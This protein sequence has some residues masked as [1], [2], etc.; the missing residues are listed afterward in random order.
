M[1]EYNI[2]G[3]YMKLLIF[4]LNKAEKFDLLLKEFAANDITGATIIS[5][6]GMA[7]ELMKK[8]DLGIIGSFR[9]L[10]DNNRRENKT[11]FMVIKEEKIPTVVEVI[12]KVV[13]NLDQPDTGIL[14]TTSLDFVKGF[15]H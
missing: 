1:K 6:T 7:R 13:G 9:H 12:E 10:L 5:S 14:F 8:D 3:D 15:K 11:M 2:F 4:V